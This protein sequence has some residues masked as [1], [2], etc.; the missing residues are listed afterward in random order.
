M[1]QNRVHSA[2][3][4]GWSASAL[5]S[6]AEFV[7]IP[8][9]SPGFDA[10]WAETGHLR[11]AVEHVRDWIAA[12]GLPGARLE[13]LELEGRSPLL[14]V[15]IPATSSTAGRGT[16][17]LY[18]HLDKQPSVG[19]WS[20]GLDPWKPVFRD[21]R[22]YGRGAVDDG[23]SGYAATLALE[24]VHAAG[25]EHVR[26][27]L[28][29]ETGE[30]S[31]SPD[32]PA[33]MEH[34]GD[35]LGEISL[36]V[37][38]DAGG[39]DYERLWLTNSL[40]GLAQATV[41][42]S[43]LRTPQHS[44]LAS[45]IVP[46]SFRI[47]RTLLDRIEDAATGVIKLPAMNVEI[48]ADR[49]AEAE[50]LAKSDP[51][52]PKRQHPLLDGV[53]PASDD[54]VELI[55]NNTWRPT[56]S[57]TGAS[58][59]PEPASA[60]NVLRTSTSLKL[61]FRLP[62]TADSQAA[63]AELRQALTTDVPYDAK[64]EL[65]DVIAQDGWNAPALAPWLSET[66][67]SV[68]DRVLGERHQGIGI[69]GAVPFMTMLAERYPEAQFLVTGALGVDSNMHVPDEWL[70]LAFAQKVTEAVAHVL[71]AHARA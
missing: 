51:G 52:A 49:R 20:E 13:I 65:A 17:I 42:V 71:D 7:E 29:L 22:L 39:G 67:D 9:L 55:L 53:R 16:A 33:Y 66:L 34:L 10:S 26:V 41:T 69:G 54:D 1:D 50:E 63:L 44:G 6:L 27:V 35:R 21:G 24:A 38:L 3:A 32:L 31:G 62:P 11:A 58:G 37:C 43:V 23:Y 61:S 12:R 15:D 40:R 56:L 30:E 57:V 36:V 64:V 18:G 46:S 2:V 8:A 47:L 19:E 25:G 70:N 59:L 28:L 4:E 45:G 5:P 48:P 60:G 14:M 68:G